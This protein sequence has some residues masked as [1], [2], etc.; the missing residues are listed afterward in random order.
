MRAAGISAI[1]AT[2]WRHLLT[3]AAACAALLVVL[4]LATRSGGYTMPDVRAY[5]SA[6]HGG[7]YGAI[8]ALDRTLYIYPPPLARAILPLTW[9]PWPA[10]AGLWLASCAGALWWMLQPIVMPTRVP[11]TLALLLA[12][13][14]NSSVLLALA[15]ASRRP[16]AWAFPLLTKVTPG[17]GILWYAVRRE[18]R[19]LALA[20]GTT[21]VIAGLSV[22]LAPDLWAHWVA[23]VR[24]DSAH[25]GGIVAYPLPA[26]PLLIRG[27]AAAAIVA[28]GART[29]R[30][31]TLA[32]AALLA[33]PD[34][35]LSSV[36]LLAA[37]PRLAVRRHPD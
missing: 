27:V 20:L 36:P 6:W 12:S 15:I 25:Y 22:G 11:V 13:G 31:W 1:P 17:I 37:V 29:N 32:L 14:G 21:G 28:W 34:I 33:S 8:P 35:L 4:G 10:F 5:W 30:A 23:V 9:L 26:V 24:A 19:A 2:R 16:A 18:W 7:L 3:F